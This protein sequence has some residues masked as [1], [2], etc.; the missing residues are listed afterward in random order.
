MSITAAP[1][2]PRPAGQASGLEPRDPPL[3]AVCSLP[4]PWCRFASAWIKTGHV[5][6]RRCR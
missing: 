5:L 2:T 4:R 6:G 1:Q 3:C